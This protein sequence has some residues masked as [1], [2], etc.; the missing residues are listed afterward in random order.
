MPVLRHVIRYGY[1]PFML[2]GLNGLA[3][4]IVANGHSY[5]WLAPLLITA[6]VLAYLAEHTLPWHE[7]WNNGH[8]DEPANFWH[9]LVYESSNLHA[10]LC[11]P[12]VVWLFPVVGIWPTSWPLVLQLLLAIAAADF[13]FTMMHFLSHRWPL[14]WRLHAVHH[15]VGRMCGLNGVVRHPLHQSLDT[16]VGTAPLIVLGMPLEIA[17]LLG[18]AISM[19]LIVQHSNVAYALGPLR[20]HLS[21]GQIHHLHHVNW[22]KEGDCNFGLFFTWWD[23]VLGTLQAEPPRPV[24]AN[25]LGVDE[26]PDFPK[27]YLEQLVFPFLYV[28]GHGPPKRFFKTS[29]HEPHAPPHPE[30]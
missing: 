23:R 27:S 21:I 19:Q 11:I 13:A 10:I 20:N 26:V 22:G 6:F 7:E 12:I 24:G 28:P 8:G 9:L 15:G 3:Y 25:D 16:I 5:L 1:V 30:E 14:L 4:C 17:V 18:F 29:K 2:L